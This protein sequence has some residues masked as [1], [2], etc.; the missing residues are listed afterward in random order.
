MCQLIYL[1]NAATTR[2]EE[3]VVRVMEE[4]LRDEYGN[5]SSVY[6]AGAAA[7]SLVDRS[8]D[9]VARLA[10]ALSDEIYFTSGGSEA[11]NWALTAAYEASGNP[12][13]HIITTAI[14]H[15]AVLRTCDY[16]KKRGAELTILE[17]DSE[18]R[19]SAESVERA[20]RPET[21]LISVM[22]AN[23]EIGTIEPVGEIGDVARRHG[24]LFHTDAVQAFGHIPVD[25]RKMN[26]DMMSVS[27]HKF[28][29]PK[30]VGMLFIRRGVRIGSFIRGG[31]QERGRRAGTENVPGIA[32]FG[33]AAGLACSGMEKYASEEK[34]LRDY[35]IGLIHSLIPD[36]EING[37]LTE[38]LPGN[39]SVTI[40]GMDG[41]LAVMMMDRRGIAVSSGSACSSGSTDPS[42][43]MKA[44]GRS[45]RQALGTVRISLSHHNT[46]EEI[47]T[48]VKILADVADT[49]R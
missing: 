22:T 5:P 24:I 45:D 2:P 16:L 44:I 39:I 20:I 32:G 9:A 46:R 35:G 33:E 38:R 40:P 48:A 21:V 47:E 10:G 34:E 49:L 27:A 25:V 17:P 26:I 28:G 12:H 29:G 13:A 1:D 11:D 30:G 19:I 23:N 7:R 18:G 37:D 14:E 4:S 8:R 43:V 6:R 31:A 36:A 15:H 41:A 3:S 42:H